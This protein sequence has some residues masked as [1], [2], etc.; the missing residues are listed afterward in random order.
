MGDEL[1]LIDF[2]RDLKL[3]LFFL[4]EVEELIVGSKGGQRSFHWFF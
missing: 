3:H 1:E 4:R 2:K